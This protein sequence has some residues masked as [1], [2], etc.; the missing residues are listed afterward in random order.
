[1]NKYITEFIGTFFFVLAIGMN[2]L[3]PDS[4]EMAPL[5]IGA[6][7]MVMVYAGWHIS[8]A[9]YNPAVTLAV[10]I[11]GKFDSKDVAPYIY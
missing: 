4:A 7:L 9:H 2:V 6:T 5:A 3:S 10:Y 11:R 8:G 1:M